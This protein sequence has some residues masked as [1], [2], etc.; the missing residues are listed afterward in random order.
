MACGGREIGGLR[1]FIRAGLMR[2]AQIAA[3]GFAFGGALIGPLEIGDSFLVAPCVVDLDAEFVVLDRCLRVCGAG[4]QQ[5]ERR[6]GAQR[7]KTAFHA[8]L[9]LG[10]DRNG[11]HFN[12]YVSRKTAR[13]N[14]GSGRRLRSKIRAVYAIEVAELLH[15]REED[16]GLDHTFQSGTGIFQHGAQIVHGA[17]HLVFK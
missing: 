17:P 10:D 2:V 16:G 8:R 12:L 9:L 13:L 5:G 1:E 3:H 14:A 15:V 4:S 6:T 11:L 7:G